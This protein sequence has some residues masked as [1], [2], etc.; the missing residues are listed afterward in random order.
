MDSI[1]IAASGMQ[2]DLQRLETI[3]QNVA[4]VLTPGYKRQIVAGTPFAAY[5]QGG[6]PSGDSRH[7]TSL[8][9]ALSIDPSAGSLRYSANMQDVAIEGNGFFE[10]ESK[11]GP[12]YTRQ[13]GLRVDMNGRLVGAHDLPL[14]GATG[15]ITLAPGGFSV[16]PNGDVLQDGRIAGRLKLVHFENPETLIPT[17]GGL[18][19]QG[20]ARLAESGMQSQVRAGFQETSNVN[21]AHEMVRLTETVRHFEALQKIVQGYDDILEKTI[22]KL[23]EF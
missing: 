10:L 5:V 17:G 19:I 16:S 23:G 20:N 18:Y 15:V 21:S 3:S 9:S 6:A 8:R 14:V 22:R 13:G 2:H 11:T 4:N 12:Q 1:A 7:Q